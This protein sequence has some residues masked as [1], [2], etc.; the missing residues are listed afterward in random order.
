MSIQNLLINEQ[1]AYL[2][3][4]VQNAIID[5]ELIAG[6]QVVDNIT[7]QND[8]TV[9]NDLIVLGDS[10][11]NGVTSST[12]NNLGNIQTD[13]LTLGNQGATGATSLDQYLKGEFDWQ[14]SELNVLGST[15]FTGLL[16][17]SYTKC[18]NVATLLME[19]DSLQLGVT[20]YFIMAGLPTN[21]NPK[22]FN[23]RDLV[24]FPVIYHEETGS[25][26]MQTDL[27]LSIYGPTNAFVPDNVSYIYSKQ[28]YID[29]G[30]LTPG[31]YSLEQQMFTYITQD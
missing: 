30:N 31:T 27:F 1:K 8:L 21:L 17:V 11:L 15:G 6:D 4:R 22:F 18:G 7:V 24:S 19:Q 29:G 10:S 9:N 25:N 28:A 23:S 12:I 13:T 3:I 16:S 26:V 5:G 20:G 2:N 14:W